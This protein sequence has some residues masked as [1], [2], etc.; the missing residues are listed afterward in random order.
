MMTKNSR[1]LLFVFVLAIL[2]APVVVG[3]YLQANAGSFGGV[4]VGSLLILYIAFYAGDYVFQR[5][6]ILANVK[7]VASDP[8]IKK[9]T[10]DVLALGIW[11]VGTLLCLGKLGEL[12][13]MFGG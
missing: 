12:R 4:F 10:F 11:L 6:R 9:V 13:R 2:F 8:K 7:I 3:A 1:S 5:P